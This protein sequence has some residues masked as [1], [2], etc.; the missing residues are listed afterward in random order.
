MAIGASAGGLEALKSLLAHLPERPGACVVVVQ[1]LD[2]DHK[3]LLAEL[4]ARV[5]TLPV[6]QAEDG[7]AVEA[8]RIV[9]IPENATLLLD[10]DVL[11]VE[12]P[13]P[14]RPQ[15]APIDT[16]L[17]SVARERADH[18]VGVILSGAGSD[19]TGG[20]RELKKAGGFVIAQDP[21]EASYDSMPRSAISTGLT[22][23]VLPAEAI[24]AAIVAHLA[25]LREGIDRAVR[26]APNLQQTLARICQYLRLATGHDFRHYKEPTLL[27]RVNR[28]MHVLDM[29]SAEQYAGR[30]RD[31]PAEARNLFRDLLISVTAFFRDRDAFR[32]LETAIDQMLA[33]KAP[34]ETIRVW[35]P[36]CATGEEAY[37][38]AMLLRDRIDAAQ[39][40]Q[41]IQIFATDIDENALDLARR[42]I[43][44]ESVAGYLPEGYLERYFRKRGP[45]YQVSDEIRELCIFSVQSVIK[46][47]PFSRLD[48]LS[49]RNLLIYLKAEMQAKLIP[50][51]HY[52]LRPDGLLMLG[53]SESITGHEPLFAPI[54]KK[55]RLFRYCEDEGNAPRFPLMALTGEPTQAQRTPPQQG[56]AARDDMVTKAQKLLLEEVGPGYIIAGANREMLYSG[57]PVGRYLRLQS[58]TPSLELVN[59]IAPALRMDLR[60]LWHRVISEKAPATRDMVF[61]DTETGR[62]R[63]RL[64]VRP[65]DEDGRGKLTYLITFEDLGP[66]GEMP[67]PSEQILRDTADIEAMEAELRS[68]REYLQTTTEEL[69]SSNEELKSANEELMSM[70]EELQSS[71]EELVTSKEELQSV[72]EE[73]E[74]VNVELSHKVDELAK[75]N[76]DLENFLQ[77][78][79]VATLFLDRHA[80]VRR[81]TPAAQELFHLL[82]HDIGR[83]IADITSRVAEVDIAAE[84][85][86]VLR[87]LQPV[88]RQV[89]LSS[90]KRSFIMRLTPYRS[91]GNVV[92]GTVATFSDVTPLRDAQELADALN[93]RLEH[94]VADLTALL[95]LVPIG[96]VFADEP[97]CRCIKVN[98][99]A[100]R[101]LNLGDKT[102]ATG[103]LDQ[104]SV[105]LRAGEKVAPRDLPLETV[106]RTGAPVQDFRARYVGADGTEFDM[107]MSAAPVF[108][109]GRNILRVV[110]I[111]N[112]ITDL[113]SAQ[114]ATENRERYNRYVAEI[115][116]KSLAGVQARSLIDG[117]PARLTE[118][119]GVELAEVLLLRPD[120]DALDLAAAQGLA[121]AD[122]TRVPADPDGLAGFAL[123][124]SEPVVVSDLARDS[125]FTPSPLLQQAG[126]VSGVSVLIGTGRE[127]FGVLS[128]FATHRRDFVQD[129]INLAQSV[130]YLLAAALRRDATDLQKQLL[131]EELRHRVK[132][133]LATVQSVASLSLREAR[134]DPTVARTITERFQALAL[135]HDL[136]FRR[137]DGNVALNELVEVQCAPYDSERI[138]ISGNCTSP[139]DPNQAIDISMIIHELVTNA[140]KHGGLSGDDGRIEITI[141]SG[142]DPTQPGCVINWQE[143]GA[144]LDPEHIHRG[145]GSKLIEAISMQ[146]HF[147]IDREIGTDTL[148]Y[149]IRCTLREA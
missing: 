105:V 108:D 133:M 23:Q 57:G 76:A 16:F 82:T 144:V 110:G 45:E 24:G 79:D 58:G 13:A 98:R 38:I 18:G 12:Q 73:L 3:S 94:R 8:D 143:Y 49:C 126:A 25:A 47:P 103:L 15:R 66:A 114:E 146:A 104:G 2:P 116:R 130:A 83:P 21:E 107:L 123:G 46:D 61:H 75:L 7:M 129:E 112:D 127:P 62:R 39:S 115:G 51:F 14:P 132:N 99:F 50:V 29:A 60:A 113:V 78:T 28:R 88:E 137:N 90:G 40:A 102:E 26:D 35:V 117:A 34:G 20:V 120:G 32:A 97:D 145:T 9:V 70:N 68:A 131:L 33:T 55:W 1:H 111:I 53:P 121:A 149:T 92:D 136:N 142:P 95:D 65:L 101:L 81:F 31:D 72:N 118:V 106:W 27:R 74:T 84:V 19:G 96:I 17:A 69:E 37:S 100:A 30:L 67:N 134:T 10:G 52:A 80:R 109:A 56:S 71:N 128:L 148:G 64:T 22:D 85:D 119:T 91:P 124:Q 125:R 138:A 77:S 5:A 42:G 59:L 43:Y 89:Q 36:G 41:R 135:A 140:V 93:H 48:L 147:E 4:L 54:D 87:T 122:G 141:G 63:L 139:L 86:S 44:P 11:R 6:I